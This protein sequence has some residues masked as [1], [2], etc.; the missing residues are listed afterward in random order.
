MLLLVCLLL[1]IWS[2]TSECISSE[3]SK[4][5]TCPTWMYPNSENNSECVCGSSLSGS[6]LCN[7]ES[8]TVHL[9]K[10]FCT[11][12]SEELGTTLIGNCPYSLGG[13][14]P[15]NVSELKDDAGFCGCLHRKGQLCGECEDNYTLPVYSYNQGCVKCKDFK[16]GWIKSISAAFLPLTL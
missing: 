1:A 8:S 10:H 5:L 9:A 7:A 15:K 2:S 11:Y 16:H 4:P 12:F 13:L 6:V 3:E 14:L